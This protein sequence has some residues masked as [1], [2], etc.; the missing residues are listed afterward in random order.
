MNNIV[1]VDEVSCLRSVTINCQRLLFFGAVD[2]K[3][4]YSAVI[5]HALSW[6]VNVKETQSKRKVNGEET[7]TTPKQE[8]KEGIKNEKKDKTKYADFVSMTEEE[9]KKLTDLHGDKNTRI[10]IEILDNYKGSN[11]KRYK[12]DYRAILNW[13]ID[14]AKQSGKYERKPVM[15]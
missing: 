9:H 3:G 10:L 13:V 1:N 2:E 14:R 11:G 5:I 12:N 6:A 4:Y 7:E 15:P 8:C